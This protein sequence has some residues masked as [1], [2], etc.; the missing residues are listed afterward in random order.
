M[1]GGATP[2]AW[3]DDGKG[4]L[5]L[6]QEV[7][8]SSPQRKLSGLNLA[9][10]ADEKGPCAKGHRQQTCPWRVPEEGRARLPMEPEP[11]T[12]EEQKKA[13]GT[14]PPVSAMAPQE[15]GAGR[16]FFP[17]LSHVLDHF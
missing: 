7:Y 5:S 9:C 13:Q 6:R 3:L 16:D 1:S 14:R 17:N 4:G 15:S 8:G 12:W 10:P 11:S 2:T